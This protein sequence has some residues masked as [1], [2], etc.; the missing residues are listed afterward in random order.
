MNRHA[1][2]KACLT[3]I[4]AALL[5]VSCGNPEAANAPPLAGAAIGGPFTLTDTQGKQV[6]WS[7]FAGKYRV[8]Y[9]GYAYC[10]DVCPLDVQ[11]IMKGYSLFKEREPELAVQVQP[12]FI[13]VDPQRDTPAVMAEFLSNFP[14]GMIGLTGPVEQVNAAAKAFGVWVQREEPNEEGG[15]LVNHTNITYLMGREGE[16][17]AV[18]PVDEGPEAIAA[19]LERWTG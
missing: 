5:L 9:F 10:P 15:Y 11:R 7:D 3:A 13:S 6:S 14:G 8:V 12:I 1:M 16:P 19:E 17:I 4:S 2:L 18:L